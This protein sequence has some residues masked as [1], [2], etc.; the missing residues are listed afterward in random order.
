MNETY[1]PMWAPE[2]RTTY[3]PKIKL[4]S[5]LF[6]F[7]STS[8]ASVMRKKRPRV[9]DRIPNDALV[10]NAYSTYQRV[11]SSWDM[12]ISNAQPLVWRNL[13][14]QVIEEASFSLLRVEHENSVNLEWTFFVVKVI[15]CNGQKGTWCQ[16]SLKMY[17]L[18]LAKSYRLLETLLMQ[19]S[20][21]VYRAH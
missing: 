21:N 14:L 17:L 6:N 7:S 11:Y 2:W 1:S 12:I 18:A 8:E 5:V 3:E 20:S 13:R 19:T 10:A 4:P 15:F 16:K 9:D